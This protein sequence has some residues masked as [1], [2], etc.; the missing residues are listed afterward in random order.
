VGG[1][2]QWLTKEVSFWGKRTGRVGHAMASVL[3]NEGNENHNGLLQSG[4]GT[5]GLGTNIKRERGKRTRKKKSIGSRVATA[6]E[7]EN[8]IKTREKTRTVSF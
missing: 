8:V 7:I 4:Q 6:E 3:T 2:E 1:T 5:L